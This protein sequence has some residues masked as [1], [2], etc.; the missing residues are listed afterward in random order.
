VLEGASFVGGAVVAGAEAARDAV[1]LVASLERAR[2]ADGFGLEDGADQD[3]VVRT[4]G[5][6]ERGAWDHQRRGGVAR[7]HVDRPR[8][9]WWGSGIGG[10]TDVGRR[11]AGAVERWGGIERGVRRRASVHRRVVAGAE[12]TGVHAL[13]VRAGPIVLTLDG[14]A[15]LVEAQMDLAA[16]TSGVPTASSNAGE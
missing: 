4:G 1:D 2:D 11:V 13:A 9:E 8:Q 5:E 6:G 14:A 15:R 3:D 12:H 7:D 16:L 10:W